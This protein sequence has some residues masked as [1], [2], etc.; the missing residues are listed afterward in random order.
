MV[1]AIVSATH[2]SEEVM[3]D[4]GEFVDVQFR[5]TRDALVANPIMEMLWGGKL[6]STLT[7]CTERFGWESLPEGL[8][9]IGPSAGM[10]TQ[11]E[12]HLFPT[13][14]RYKYHKLRPLLQA[15]AEQQP[16]YEYLIS[17]D[18]EIIQQNWMTLRDCAK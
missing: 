6:P 11:L 8:D 4:Q 5:S 18:A 13:M 12:H 7:V 16:D 2:Q 9:W 1:G 10:D 15:F 17:S 3:F 14:P